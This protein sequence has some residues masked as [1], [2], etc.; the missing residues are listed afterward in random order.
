M[1]GIAG[2]VKW[3][4]F[5]PES[6]RRAITRMV[7][8]LR[9]RGPDE[10]AAVGFPGM[11]AALGAA[12]LSL[13]D[14]VHGQQPVANEDATVWAVLNGEIYNHRVLRTKLQAQ[15]H[16]FRTE[17]DTE[18]LVHLYEERGEALFGE[19]SGMYAAG[20]VD[21][22]RRRVLVGR[23]HIGMKPLYYAERAGGLAF[24]S[25][26]GA[27]FAGG[28]VAPEADREALG[29]YFDFGYI[30]APGCAFRGL[31][32][33]QAGSYLKWDEETGARVERHWHPP[34]EAEEWDAGAP[35]RLEGLLREA[36]ATH[37][38]GD[39]EVGCFLSGGWDSSIVAALAR[40]RLG[41][42]KTFSLVFPESPDLDES[43]HARAV[44]KALGTEHFE[45]EFRMEM[46]PELI[47]E[48]VWSLG[49]PSSC[50][51]SMLVGLISGLAAG[52]VKTVVGGEGSD[53]LFAG[54][55]WLGPQPVYWLNR[56]VPGPVA[57][58]LRGLPWDL[59]WRRALRQIGAAT[60]DDID[61]EYVKR[62]DVEDLG[63]SRGF[64]GQPHGGRDAY[65]VVAATLGGEVVERTGAG[66]AR[67]LL[68]EMGGRLSNGILVSCD[69]VSMA[70]G[71]EVRLPFLDR[72]VVEFAMRQPGEWKWRKG[73]EKAILKP[74]VEKYV[75]VV[76]GRRKLGLQ[77]PE[78]GLSHE[79]VRKYSYRVL[80]EGNGLF[81][82]AETEAL[83]DRWFQREP[84][85]LRFLRLLVDFQVWWNQY[86]GTGGRA[87]R[88]WTGA[89]VGE[90]RVD[91]RIAG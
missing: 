37:L 80:L 86:V 25:E 14:V 58:L 18:V 48:T 15:G 41:R 91:W 56:V 82:R 38:Q 44:A 74:L 2:V 73:Q 8:A 32:K 39:V 7:G 23:D 31:R 17:C 75:P 72:G 30:P 11:D 51:P 34:F 42:L 76:A 70:Q 60:R 66:L 53:E 85:E 3:P 81:P 46:F 35:E 67:R 26:V 55:G 79:A 43:A 1:C 63:V 64:R 29:G 19:L 90:E 65:A 52:H 54:Y 71:L 83:L 13:V 21:L 45:V 84:R 77:I 16:R 59:R 36:T 24:A 62:S 88:L 33:L 57:R 9:H 40:E 49:E 6:N 5:G 12:R 87:T 78:R 68:L 69:R 20:I 27:F 4:G 10:Q 28:V 47:E 61:F 22:K 50:T 89:E